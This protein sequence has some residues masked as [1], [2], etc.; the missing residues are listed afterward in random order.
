MWYRIFSHKA[1]FNSPGFW[2][3]KKNLKTKFKENQK[4]QSIRTKILHTQGV[5]QQIKVF[6]G[7]TYNIGFYSLQTIFS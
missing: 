7:A 2:R 5:L 6:R 4:S 3:K 1:I